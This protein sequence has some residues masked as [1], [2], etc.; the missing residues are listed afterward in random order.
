MN[1]SEIQNKFTAH[2]DVELPLDERIVIEKHFEGCST[3]KKE[4][5]L[6]KATVLSLG[7]LDELQAP[8]E[9]LKGLN[10]KID[11]LEKRQD[12]ARSFFS[13]KSLII[14]PQIASFIMILIVGGLVYYMYNSYSKLSQNPTSAPP[15]RLAPES[16]LAKS[17]GSNQLQG[18]ASRIEV[19][20][21]AGKSKLVNEKIQRLVLA[22]KGQ[23]IGLKN[24]RF[25][26]SAGKSQHDE[27]LITIPGQTYR[28]FMTNLR[29]AMA[30]SIARKNDL[31][32][33]ATATGFAPESQLPDRTQ[34][35]N[36][37]SSAVAAEQPKDQNNV[38][39]DESIPEVKLIKVVFE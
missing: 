38:Q 11:R 9:V 34:L 16:G 5:E 30:E 37:D 20:P 21:F 35:Q 2:Y 19:V 25:E 27:L 12:F 10:E 33:K 24:K 17:S 36:V 18:P 15:V 32:K 6:F 3:C 23:I 31:E 28:T 8:Y 1:C 7:S 39:K 29:K 4:Y 14:A 22:S 26:R 13:N